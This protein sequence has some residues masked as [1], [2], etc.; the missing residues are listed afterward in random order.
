MATTAATTLDIPLTASPD[1]IEEHTNQNPTT[2]FSAATYLT[3]PQP[4][5]STHSRSASSSTHTLSPRD[6]S[7]EAVNPLH[8]LAFGTHS[9]DRSANSSHSLSQEVHIVKVKDDRVQIRTGPV[10]EPF[11]AKVGASLVRAADRILDG[12]RQSVVSDGVGPPPPSPPASHTGHDDEGE[13][14]TDEFPAPLGPSPKLPRPVTFE[15]PA[16]VPSGSS[17]RQYTKSP[18]RLSH[19]QSLSHRSSAETKS[20]LTSRTNRITRTL[21]N[22]SDGG[23]DANA[24]EDG[25]DGLLHPPNHKYVRRNTIG[26]S[27]PLSSASASPRPPPARGA[28]MHG[29]HP[30]YEAEFDGELGEL[31]TD[32]QQQA[33][34]IRKERLSR[35]A[36]AAQE[37]EQGKA[38]HEAEKAL[39]RTASLVR[40][41]SKSEDNPLVGNLIG[42]GHVNYV[43][44]YNMLTGIRIA[45]SRWQ[46]KLTRPLVDE[47]FSAAHKYSFDM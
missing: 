4:A 29:A 5:H 47:D 24:G 39:T 15:D 16:A 38:K 17:L 18:A 21:T 7:P 20:S 44:M 25:A 41:F 22:N 1:G 8:A 37:A 35:R 19:T 30:S 36:K 26:S 32:I 46:A 14:D 34:Q 31:A 23:A 40:A 6:S 27:A 45:V 9:K 11:L 28:T 13:L 2:S 3:A 10:P 33:E 12:D 42:E 43:L